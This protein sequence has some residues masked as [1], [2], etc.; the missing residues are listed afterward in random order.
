MISFLYTTHQDFH[1]LH[2]L[3]TK[4]RQKPHSEICQKCIL[5]D[6]VFNFL[7]DDRD[8]PVPSQRIKR[9]DND[10]HFNGLNHM[11]LNLSRINYPDRQLKYK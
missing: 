7:N 6:A 10:I 3:L 1:K 4:G 5:K 2:K 9:I 8:C 11:F